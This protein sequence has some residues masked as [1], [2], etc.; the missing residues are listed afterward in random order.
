[1]LA[2]KPAPTPVNLMIRAKPLVILGSA[3]RKSDTKSCVEIV[4]KNTEI[5]L[6]D[7]LDFNISPFDY[8]SDYPLNDDFDRMINEMIK[9]RVIVFAT[10]V[11]WYSMSGL[12]RIL[13]DRFTDLVTLKKEMGRK[14]KG[15]SIFL[16]AV[17][18]DSEL[19]N[20]FETP[21]KL[22][23]DYLGMN[24]KTK[25]YFSRNGAIEQVKFDEIKLFKDNI[26][27]GTYR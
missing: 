15:I 13:F 20:G 24:Y 23:A 10:P 18:V 21:F 19:P 3:R 2:P 8:E 27:A 4:F 9:H 22:T 11:Y 5:D 17:G 12:M 6:L 14:M 1:V 26:Q 16:L 7:L 25:I